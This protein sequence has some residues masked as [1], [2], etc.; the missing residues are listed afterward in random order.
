M[1]GLG[2]EYPDGTRTQRN[3]VKIDYEIKPTIRG[4]KLGKD[5]LLSKAVSLIEN[6]KG[7]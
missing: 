4:V 5:E 2:I 6:K 1:S 3:G 7:N